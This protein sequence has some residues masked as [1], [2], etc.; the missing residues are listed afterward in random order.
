MTT[1]HLLLFVALPC[2]ILG[3][4]IGYLWGYNRA[5]KKAKITE[6]I[7]DSLTKAFDKFGSDE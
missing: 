7:A 5:L 3:G 1:L 2:L 4:V 6:K